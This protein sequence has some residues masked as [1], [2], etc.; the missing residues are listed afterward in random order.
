VATVK[1]HVHIL[2]GKLQVK[3]RGEAAVLARRAVS[4]SPMLSG[5]PASR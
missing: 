4:A 1:N 5:R 2:L 3:R